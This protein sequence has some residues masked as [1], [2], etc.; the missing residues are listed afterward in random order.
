MY[1]G[2][3]AVKYSDFTTVIWKLDNDRYSRFIIDNYSDNKE[4]VAHNFITQDGNYT[5][6]LQSQTIVVLQGPLYK[7]PATTLPSVLTVGVG[8]AYVFN[9][10]SY[11][12]GTWRRGDINESFTITDLNGEE[13]QIPPS[14]QWVHILPNEGE[15]FIDN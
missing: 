8:S 4:A 5:D 3:I 15:V 13:V 12:E 6:I 9:N 1:A 14:T 11:I 2:P 10:G 7:D